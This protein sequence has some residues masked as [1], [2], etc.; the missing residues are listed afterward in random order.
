LGDFQA[1]FGQGIVMGSG[2]APRKSALVT[3]VS[4]NYELLR[5]YRSAN[6]IGFLRGAAVTLG[7]NNFLFTP[8][9][10]YKP[11]SSTQLTDSLN[12][13]IAFSSEITGGLFRTD[14]ELKNR[15]NNNQFLTGANLNYNIYTFNL[16]LTYVYA[17]YT[18]PANEGNKL[19]QQ[20]NFTGNNSQ[21]LGLNYTGTL[22]SFSLF[23]EFG[24]SNN[25]NSFAG[26]T[27]LI[28]PLHSKL[29]L[30]FLYRNYSKAYYTP[31]TNAFGEYVG[32]NNE[33]GLYSAIAFKPTSK[34]NINA[35]YDIFYSNWFRYLINA[36]LNGIDFLTDIQFIPARGSQIY[37]RY[38]FE[39]KQSNA[40][41]SNNLYNI[42]E[43]KKQQLR[44]HWQ[45]NIGKTCII[46][47]RIEK[48]FY[49][50]TQESYYEG[51]LFFADATIKLLNNKL[52]VTGRM[53]WFDVDDFNARIY[54]VESDVLYQYA[55]PM[56]QNKGYRY[57]AI[58]NYQ[59]SKKLE[60]WVKYGQTSYT[61][62][63]KISSG[64]EEIN[65]NKLQEIRFQAL[66]KF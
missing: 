43:T 62:I 17:N 63:N 28:V 44:L 13:V 2:I 27:G 53:A 37:L 46:K 34:W 65:G 1:N 56:F 10:S 14:S 49:T 16:G 18:I 15:N 25:H 8:F 30:I 64:N 51:T 5:P 50:E 4:R 22:R 57:Y 52:Q 12:N 40:A 39:R 41:N 9:I 35:Y 20:Y 29:D 47:S 55:I 48:S 58:I 36:P 26:N 61:N 11:I 45:T 54:A 3:Q 38:R 6:Q 33:K 31:Y 60:V 24:L 42:N 66:I 23:G 32:T 21:S 59:Y 7:Y 19:H